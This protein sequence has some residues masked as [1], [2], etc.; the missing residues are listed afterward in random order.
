MVKQVRELKECEMPTE[1]RTL[2]N[3]Y[4]LMGGD[5]KDCEMLTEQET[6]IEY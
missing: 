4:T 5:W 3:E 6:M 2:M 1:Q